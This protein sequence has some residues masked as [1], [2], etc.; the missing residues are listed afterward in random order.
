MNFQEGFNSWMK[1][2]KSG[3]PNRG[4]GYFCDPL[5]SESIPFP[6]AMAIWKR[7]DP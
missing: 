3:M 5:R 2:G 6:L 1:I 4:R 7:E